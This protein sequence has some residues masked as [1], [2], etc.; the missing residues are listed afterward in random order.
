MVTLLAVMLKAMGMKCGHLG[1]AAL[2]LGGCTG[3]V[4]SPNGAPDPGPGLEG[5]NPGPS[6]PIGGGGNNG[7]GNNGGGGPTQQPLPPITPAPNVRI[8]RLTHAQWQATVMDLFGLDAATAP[9]WSATFR[10]DVGQNGFIFDNQGSSLVVDGTLQTAYERAAEEVADNVTASGSNALAR[11]L[12]STG[13]D[14]E[15]ARTFVTAF[16]ERAH[17]RPLGAAEIDAYVQVFDTGVQYPMGA[18]AFTAGLRL[19]LKAFL[20]APKF[21][22][23]IEL[24][25]APTDGV[26]PLDDYEV[27]SRLSYF[28]WNTTPDDALL[29]AAAAGELSTEAGVRQQANRMLASPR[30]AEVSER[31]HAVVLEMSR[32]DNINP[33]PDAFPN[34]PS[35]LPALA[36]QETNMVLRDAFDNDR[37]WRSLL[38][39]NETFVNQDLAPLYGLSGGF[40]PAF[41]RVTLDNSERAG[42]LTQIGFLAAHATQTQPDPIHR[43]VYVTLKVA[44]NALG[45]PPDNL[46]PLPAPEPGQTNREAIE[47]LTEAPGTNCAGCH[48]SII[49][50]F[51]FPFEIYDAVG[52]V[53]SSDNGR[54]VDATATVKVQTSPAEQ[55]QNGVELAAVLAED[56]FV[57]QCYV[58]HWVEYAFGRRYTAGDAGLIANLGRASRDGASIRKVLA[59]L[60]SSPAFLNRTTE[61]L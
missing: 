6:D 21:L 22:Y 29:A 59:D 25:T 16:G 2:L 7:G 37:G 54:T 60:V 48:S 57:H 1:V 43:G 19:V 11:Y 10:T 13:T 14:A 36:R 44:C 40:G 53:R 58:R 47:A 33:A 49:N 27:A 42:L 61:E 51:G 50:P 15:R 9:D 56:E 20:T 31:F 39:T 18:A 5:P 38:T 32:Y 3:T 46:P 52:Q 24:S 35:D 17:R 34:A 41:E 45:A 30:A 55:V 23:R 12:P 26:V 4:L 28:L 8:A